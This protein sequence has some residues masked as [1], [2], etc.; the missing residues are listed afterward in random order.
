MIRDC[1]MC[2]YHRDWWSLGLAFHVF[3]LYWGNG[4]STAS[5]IDKT[6]RKLLELFARMVFIYCL[7][8]AA[9]EAGSAYLVV[10][11]GCTEQTQSRILKVENCDLEPR[12]P[13]QGA[14][15]PSASANAGTSFLPSAQNLIL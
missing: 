8:T 15:Y 7:P 9:V 11:V 3:A 10:V 14:P 12:R 6:R 1:P 13:M 4:Q 2:A 5:Q